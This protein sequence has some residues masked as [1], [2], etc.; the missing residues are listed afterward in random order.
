MI[1]DRD[2]ADKAREGNLS[3]LHTDRAF[4]RCMEIAHRKWRWVQKKPA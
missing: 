4:A 2:Y 3:F 1:T